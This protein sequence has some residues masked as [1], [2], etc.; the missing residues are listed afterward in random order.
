MKI[1]LVTMIEVDG[2]LSTSKW[3]L[4]LIFRFGLSQKII[5]S[6][7]INLLIAADA[8]HP[9]NN[10]EYVNLGL[11]CNLFNTLFIRAGQSHTLFPQIRGWRC[12]EL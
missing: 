7:K 6:E 5:F 2:N 4:P 11:E 10:P 9:N 12:Q 8:I 1:S 3:P